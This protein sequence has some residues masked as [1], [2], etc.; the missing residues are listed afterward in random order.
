VV[1]T[2]RRLAPLLAIAVLVCLIAAGC[3]DD[4]DADAESG[5]ETAAAAQLRDPK[6]PPEAFAR[7][8][9]K[10][11]ADTLTRKDCEGL[12][13]INAR[14]L[15]RFQCPSPD[16]VRT[17]LAFFKVLDAASFGTGAVV[18]Y[19]TEQAPRGASMVLFLGPNR[20]WGLSHFGLIRQD[21]AESSDAD[22]REG[23]AEAMNGY[24]EAVR[25]RDCKG[26]TRYAAILADDV[27]AA[28][29]P[30]LKAATRLTQLLNR[31]RAKPRYLGGNGTYG[32]YR[33][34]LSK[35]T[36][37]HLTF[38]VIRTPKGSLRPYLVQPAT[39]APAA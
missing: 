38:S 24:L 25:E 33:L 6:Q 28:C 36:P 27:K 30:E 14:S 9:A 32:F 13:A 18:D 29:K 31:N 26:Y 4:G 37:T 10:L 34:T 1:F 2:D 35:P 16:N 3:G 5:G 15:Y 22:S 11:V 39:F 7:E 20:E 12:D 23:Y 19:K 21:T 17:E 8:L